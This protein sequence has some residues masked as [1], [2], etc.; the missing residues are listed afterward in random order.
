MTYYVT[1]CLTSILVIIGNDISAHREILYVHTAYAFILVSMENHDKKKSVCHTR[2]YLES[3][4][5]VLH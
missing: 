2:M 1:L 5:M 4:V 3:H